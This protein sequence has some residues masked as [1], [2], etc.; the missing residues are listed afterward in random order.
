MYRNMDKT[1]YFLSIIRMIWIPFSTLASALSHI[2]VRSWRGGFFSRFLMIPARLESALV[3]FFKKVL[4]QL[5]KQILLFPCVH[6]CSQQ[7]PWKY[8]CLIQFLGIMLIELH[9]ILYHKCF[10]LPFPQEKHTN[11]RFDQSYE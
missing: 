2:G 9:L 5:H 1:S 4:K 6:T 8:D 11:N 3:G 7:N 10:H